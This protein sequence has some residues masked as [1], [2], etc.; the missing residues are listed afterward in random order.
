MY[1]HHPKETEFFDYHT[2]ETEN[3][4]TLKALLKEICEIVPGSWSDD[5]IVQ[6]RACL[7]TIAINNDLTSFQGGVIEIED[8]EDDE[9]MAEL[10]DKIMCTCLYMHLSDTGIAERGRDGWRL[11]NYGKQHGAR[12][13]KRQDGLREL[14]AIA[15]SV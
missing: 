10:F 6:E 9:K 15:K 8:F 7:M 12:L 14:L 11:T 1:S 5:S 13:A 2:F 3:Y 4:D